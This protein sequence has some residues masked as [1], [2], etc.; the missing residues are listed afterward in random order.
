MKEM[1]YGPETYAVNGGLP[2]NTQH[3]AIAPDISMSVNNI[4]DPNFGDFS[5]KG[6]DDLTTAPFVYAGWSNPTVRQLENKL[7]VL[8]KTE[9]TL[10][11]ASGMAA[12]SGTLL[13]LLKAGDHIIL[14]D[15]IYAAVSEFV[16]DAL[17]GYGIDVSVVNLT[18]PDELEQ[19]IKP[20]TKIVYAETP[21]NPLLRLTDIHAVSLVTKKRGLLFCVDSTFATPAATCPSQL[22]ADL[23]IH[24]LTKFINGHGDAMGGS[25]SGS[26]LLIAKIRAHAGVYLGASLPAHSAWLIMRGADTFYPR[27]K[28]LSDS[29]LEIARWLEKHPKVKRVN[30][31]GLPSHPQY[32]LARQQMDLF[33]GII[34]FQV[35]EPSQ[36]LHRFLN[37]AKLFLHAFSIGHQRSLV[38]Y[39]DSDELIKTSYSFTDQQEKDYREMAGEGVFRLSIGLERTDDLLAELDTVLA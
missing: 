16:R 14:S 35:T 25:V 12:I 13:S 33:G 29:A 28:T 38:V 36:I 23:V 15:V 9:D 26:H 7:S 32:E 6:M 31:P 11:T 39:L 21:C 17:P 3:G 2:L 18:R 8:E 27:M 5:A 10:V 37:E 34:S 20:N 4:Y 19:A 24:S 30:Y 1:D 22:G